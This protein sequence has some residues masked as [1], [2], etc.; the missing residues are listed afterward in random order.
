MNG[1]WHRNFNRRASGIEVL[2]ARIAP[3]SLA[4]LDVS[5]NISVLGDQGGAGEGETLVFTISGSDLHISDATSAITAGS[6]FTQNG[7]NAVFVALASFTGDLTVDSGTGAD[8]LTHSSDWVA[9][10][11][12]TFFSGTLTF[13]N[14]F[15]ITTGNTLNV[16]ASATITLPNIGSDLSAVGTGAISLTTAR[17][18]V[19]ANGA[20]ITTVNG[21]LTLSANAAG[22][23]PGNFIGVDVNGGLVQAGGT[24]VVSVMG[25]GGNDSGGGQHG[26]NVQGGGDIIGGTTGT[27]TVTGTGGPASGT[28]TGVRMN[29]S[30]STI[31]SGGAH[32][33][34]AG[35]GGSATGAVQSYGIHMDPSAQITAGGTGEVT[36][37]GTGGSDPVAGDYLMGVVVSNGSIINSSGGN[38]SVTGLG[39]TGVS[40]EFAGIFLD[41]AT[42]TA[43]GA[44]TVIVVGTGGTVSGPSL[45]TTI[46]LDVRFTSLISSSG[47]NVSV[48][49][50]GGNGTDT[51]VGASAGV[52]VFG[53]GTITAGGTGTV[54]VTGTGTN[55][56]GTGHEGVFVSGQNFN[57]NLARIGAADG[58][59]TITAISGNSSSHALVVGTNNA[60][61]I[62][63]GTD[64]P[65]TIIADS[66]N[67]GGSATISSGTGATTIATRTAGTFINLGGADVLGGSPLTLGLTDAELDTIT[68]GLV[69]IGEPDSGTITVSAPITHAN[70]L[71]LTT[72]ANIVFNAP[73]DIAMDNYLVA[74]AGGDISVNA[75]IT[76]TGAGDIVLDGRNVSGAGDI[77]SDNAVYVTNT[78]ASTLSGSVGNE[79]AFL[80]KSGPGTL[81]LTNANIY[82]SMSIDGG[83]LQIG[84]GGASNFASGDMLLSSATLIL[85]TS[86]A[87]EI[88][89]AIDGDGSIIQAGSG[90]TTLSGTNF[91]TVA[92]TIDSGILRY[93][94]NAGAPN[95]PVNLAGGILSIEISGGASPSGTLTLTSSAGSIDVAAG[96]SV[97][98]FGDVLGAGHTLTKTGAGVL[99]FTQVGGGAF[100]LAQLNITEG[101]LSSLGSNAF[102][103]ALIDIAAGAALWGDQLE[104]EPVTLPNAITFHGGSGESSNPPHAFGPGALVGV[105]FLTGTITLAEGDTAF[106]ADGTTSISG[107]LTGPGTFTKTG[108]GTLILAKSQND[109]GP[110]IITVSEGALATKTDTALGNLANELV[111]NGGNLATTGSF[112]TSRHIT[113][114]ADSTFDITG[115]LTL[116]GIVDGPGIITKA[117][118]GTLVFSGDI[119]GPAEVSSAT[120]PISIGESK[121]AFKGDG[122]AVITIVTDEFGVKKIENIELSDTTPATNIVIKGPTTPGGTLVVERITST[123]PAPEIASIV[124]KT[125]IILGDGIDD[126]IP[127]INIAGKIGLLKVETVAPNT[128][129]RLGSGLS[130]DN[131]EDDTSPDTYNNRPNVLIKTITGDGVIIDVTGDGLPGGTGGGGLGNVIINSWLGA[132]LVKTTQSIGN[133][134]LRN[135][136]A[137]VVFEVDKHGQGELT[138]AN[139]GKMV[140]Q[141]GSWGSSGSEI[142][143]EIGLFNAVGF[144]ADATITAGSFNK[145]LIKGGTFAGTA[146]FTKPDAPVPGVVTVKSDF[147]GEITS[148]ASI[149]SIG[150]KGDFKGSLAA[151][152]IG[153]ISAFLFDGARETEAGDYGNENR[154]NIVALNGSLGTLKTKSGGIANYDIYAASLAGGIAV[155]ALSGAGVEG[156]TFDAAQILSITSNL[157]IVDSV[158]AARERIGK[159]SIGDKINLS[160]TTNTKFLSG[161]NL[162]GDGLL[163]GA[164]ADTYTLAATIGKI[165]IK[166]AMAQ[167][168]ISAGF[169]PGTDLIWG[170]TDD[171]AALTGVLPASPLKVIDAIALATV[172]GTT[173]NDPVSNTIQAASFKGIKVGTSAIPLS[174]F[175]KD[176]AAGQTGTADDIR[177]RIG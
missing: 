119:T 63:T 69:Q 67:F 87:I 16:T 6:G 1:R 147:L 48:I 113:R 93:T 101:S 91:N 11:D 12:A 104:G 55:G 149:K 41:S 96:G 86:S 31:S 71:S 75:P 140:I 148:A 171:T 154:H 114:A 83:T 116:A 136:D 175:P 17:N 168:V 7:A 132:G 167:T 61:R 128:I 32:V 59:T 78:V 127:D 9:P 62:T 65:I 68:A 49:G 53:N 170:N 143:G 153:S 33:Q 45:K 108:P 25:K 23:T 43:G 24:G 111:F 79:N 172:V 152:S 124:L 15:A 22:T 35:Q 151:Q 60:G 138:T 4:T 112:T 157:P 118:T 81:I 39:G 80:S 156:V 85:N 103:T 145:F 141:K 162:G 30:G 125:G 82:S 5:G 28:N 122:T 74:T 26:V 10:G 176:V 126:G 18:I 98:W 102:G 165:T 77:F 134:I 173:T 107:K 95:G 27:M 58:A 73:I 97:T 57:A 3:A 2:E 44:G 36:V 38:V 54:S 110:G 76:T 142:E 64:N 100:N 13:N 21:D 137:N 158:F 47:G 29:G 40:N 105:D 139:I 46:G 92:I 161:V 70:N 160:G 8:S 120:G 109:F 50:T 106:R 121:L 146:T 42:I 131:T 135:G 117:G 159:I 150:V 84:T 90:T 169:T 56:T 19:L 123:D 66:A 163:A 144:L 166:G 130:Y 88:S 89:G 155:K 115:T 164:I 72:G 99:G 174:G 51:T 20:S 14:V 94:N 129:I 52:R 34:V 133:F 177:F 37:T